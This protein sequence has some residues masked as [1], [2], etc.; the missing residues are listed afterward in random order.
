MIRRSSIKV[1]L[2]ILVFTL[3]WIVVL[4]P[5]SVVSRL[6]PANAPLVLQ[7]MSGS[8]WS[9]TVAQAALVQ[10]GLVVVQGRLTWR[11]RPLSLLR[12]TPCIDLTFVDTSLLSAAPGSVAGAAC[13]SAG[14]ELALQDVSF[15]LPAGYFLRSADLRLGGGISGHLQTLS[16][17]SGSLTAL[18]GQGLWSDARIVSNELNLA[19]QT[20]PFDFRRGSDDSIVVRMDNSELL[21]SRPDIPLQISLQSTVALDGSFFTRAD[22]TVQSQTTDA[23]VDLLDVVAEPQGAGRYL[24]EVRSQP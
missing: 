4:V 20:L 24:L 15:D 1:L 11:L 6:L 9:A 19:L 12:L 3:G 14:G 22:L 7:G 5:A 23:L 2:L 18:A 17:Q 13:L 16:W 21:V 10:D 8:L